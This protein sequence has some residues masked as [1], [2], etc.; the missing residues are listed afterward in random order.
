MA[1]L[2]SRAVLALT[3]ATSIASAAPHPQKQKATAGKAIYF[4][5]ND[6]E[7]A[8]V[9]LPIGKDGM[10][11]AGSV[12]K[13]GGAGSNSIDGMTKK[14]AAPDALVGQSALTV[15]GNVCGTL[16]SYSQM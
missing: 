15:V 4:L 8:V 2:L 10:L 12:T 3:L 1:F 5:T 6:A 13:T 9:A 16:L 14:A 11:A 7:N